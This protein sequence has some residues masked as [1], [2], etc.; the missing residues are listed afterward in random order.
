[1]SSGAQQLAK[2]FEQVQ[3]LL[4]IY[5]DIKIIKT[6]GDPPEQYDI[7]Y[8]IKGYKTNPDG[9]TSPDNTHQVRISLPFGY[10][11]FPPTA[12]PLTPIFHPDIDPDA[13]RIADFWQN[14]H[15]L[16]DLIIHIGQMICGNHY[17][18]DEPFNQNAFEWFEER[19]SWLPFDILEPREEEED[20]EAETV[21][22]A[23]SPSGSGPNQSFA[24]ATDLDILKDDFDFPFDDEEESAEQEDVFSFAIEEDAIAADLTDLEGD[25]AADDMNLDFG[26]DGST[27]PFDLQVTGNAESDDLF[28]MEFDA[29]EDDLTFDLTDEPAETHSVTETPGTGNL[30]DLETE[31]ADELSTK[32]TPLE[33]TSEDIT[34]AF[35]EDAGITLEGPEPAAIT[36]DDLAGLDEDALDFGIAEEFMNISGDATADLSGLEEETAE[37]KQKTWTASDETADDEEKILSALTLDEDH[38][39]A[40]RSEDQSEAIRTLIEQKQIFSAKKIL[41]DLP[42]PDAL[43]DKK[44]F[45]L[46]I[47]SALAEAEDLY[48]KADKHEQKGELE[49]AGILLDLV[50]N[51]ATDFPGLDF[52][53][54]RIRESMMGDGK[55]KPEGGPDEKK[56]PPAHGRK[57]DRSSPRAGRKKGR[58]TLNFKVGAR[59]VVILLAAAILGGIGYGGWHIYRSDSENVQ[60]ANTTFQKAQQFVERKEFQEARKELDA[61]GAAL[62]KVL[63]FQ[64]A[65]KEAILRKITGLADTE[66]FKEGL[67]GRVLYGDQFVTVETAK[68]IDKFNTQ[69]TYAEQVLKA[70]KLDQAI[71]AYE[72]S[73]PFAQEAGFE[74]EFQSISR[75]IMEL[76]LESAMTRAK[77][78]ETEQNWFE[79]EKAYRDALALSQDIS[80]Q[81]VQND[82]ADN[83]ATAAYRYNLHEGLKAI[84][85]SEWRKSIDAF[86]AV[87]EI[88]EANPQI[89]A[90]TEITVV[91][92]LL[93]Q[94][95]L[96]SR[97][98]TARK[99]YED[100]EWERALDIYKDAILLLKTNANLLG[101]EAME[102][103]RKIEKTILTT[104]VAREQIQIEATRAEKDLEKTVEHYEAI[105]RLIENSAF[106]ADETLGKILDDSRTKSTEI[107]NQLLIST[108]EKW[109]MD[110]Y[111]KIFRDNYPSA[112]LSDL[113]NPKV[114][115]IKREGNIMIF[116]LSCTE[117]KQGSTF[118]LELNYQHDLDRDVWSLYS[119]NIEEE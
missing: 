3:K 80:P 58:G 116:N 112:E 105:A 114:R 19:K 61:A 101:Q 47:A 93:I 72:I 10:P 90:E 48:K 117:R 12:K 27:E 50:A 110:N 62:Q 40:K 41:A 99:A 4:E 82:I 15:S 6:N 65:E 70:G 13:I 94:S 83:L 21:A 64:G 31:T 108:R 42:D 60:L 111:E 20:D 63:I 24:P 23:T 87:R 11:H 85:N 68:A 2:D 22:A 107:K 118:R 56:A 89:A 39:S 33:F 36:L 74:E 26:D 35:E 38:S 52:A 67:K 96:Y 76:R 103:I 100:K 79:A 29:P 91:N 5:P 88:L 73:L 14:N 69:K 57:A 95:Q 86:Q 46:T 106:K 7:E 34:S 102:N 84:N 109:L 77:Q 71:T 25:E 66:M 17:T 75:K 32:G 53:R 51:V 59:L 113:L 49:K 30:F 78:F 54:N 45:E 18:K 9:T 98:A 81:A 43:A 115:F 97:L 92:K 8:T 37:E 55:K 1:M 44:E 16:P 104:H 119:G 28:S